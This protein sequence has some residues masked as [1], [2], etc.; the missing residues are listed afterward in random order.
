MH[1]NTRPESPRTQD[2]RT[3]RFAVRNTLYIL[4]A[5]LLLAFL[6]ASMPP[7]WAILTSIAFRIGAMLVTIGIAW[8][9]RDILI[10]PLGLVFGL[11][12]VRLFLTLTQSNQPASAHHLSELPGYLFSSL[13][14]LGTVHL[15]RIF[16][17]RARMARELQ[18][19]SE[20]LRQRAEEQQ[21][22]LIDQSRLAQ[23]G[24]MMGVVLHQWKQPLNVI[25]WSTEMLRE[26]LDACPCQ[27]P[28]AD[29]R[30]DQI[31]HQVQ[32]MAQTLER[33]RT[34]FRPE[35]DTQ[36]FLP[37]RE[38]TAVLGLLQS[39]FD[40][41]RVRIALHESVPDCQRRVRGAAIEFQQIL[42]NIL[43]NARE[44][45][46]THRRQSADPESIGNIDI[47]LDCST[48][49]AIRIRICDDGGGLSSAALEHIF[50]PHF[51]TKG[52]QGNGIGLHVCF[53]ILRQRMHGLLIAGNT[54]TGACFS[55]CV[56]ALHAVPRA[57]H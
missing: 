10:L 11:T 48:G 55:I 13:A 38:I 24:E 3:E 57:P 6:M 34:F 56:P 46:E 27:I 30:M 5:A 19:Q 15:L 49:D 37:H 7:L 32:F 18:I 47:H 9:Y 26:D 52:T 4:L 36:S 45:I 41:C 40:D 12:A 16:E 44:A 14:L 25:N 35:P 22:M 31:Q 43:V 53:T 42:L 17:S 20:H 23:M 21:Q 39:Q 51:T 1:A 29:K 2:S 8:Y 54:E 50:E 28:D 33:F